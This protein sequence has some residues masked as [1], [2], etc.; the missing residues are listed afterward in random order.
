MMTTYNNS[1]Q[2]APAGLGP[3][4]RSAAG[5]GRYVS[6]MVISRMSRLYDL[7]LFLIVLVLLNALG[8]LLDGTL[9][10]K[11]QLNSD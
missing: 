8:D 10:Y 11:L 2:Y 1:T 6:P 4:L 9:P 7:V 3:R 5:A